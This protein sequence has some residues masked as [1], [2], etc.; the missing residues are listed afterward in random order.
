MGFGAL[1]VLAYQKFVEKN[2][3]MI[4]KTIKK[5]SEFNQDAMEWIKSK[6]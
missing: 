4:N 5:M 6:M 3:R 1:S 2:R